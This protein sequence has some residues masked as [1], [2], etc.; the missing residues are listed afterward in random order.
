VIISSGRAEFNLLSLPAD[1]FPN[2]PD[3]SGLDF[4]KLEA[5]LLSRMIDQTSFSISTDETRSHINGALFQGDGKSLRMVT[6]DGHR[7]SKVEFLIEESGFYNFS[8]VVPN[9]GVSEVRRLVED[10]EGDI[11][12][13][14][15]DG[16]VFFRRE[17]EIEKEKDGEEPVYSE[18]LLISKLIEDEFPPFDQVIPKSNDKSLFVSRLQ[19]LDALK[20]VSVVSAER[21][22]GVKF[23]LKEG[24]LEIVTNNPSVGRGLEVID[25]VYDEEEMVIGFNARYLIDILSVLDDDEIKLE[26][27]GPLD[28]VNVMDKKELF[29]GVVMPM[30]I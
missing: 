17:I 27:S 10:G 8:M 6:T 24:S 30:R 18:I 4:F 11:F 7:L 9:R 12:L 3:T 15:L 21:T 26:F 16:S 2:I 1:D 25:I 14:T 5:S 19:L 28:P 20:R 13:S 22:L 23:Q 29:I